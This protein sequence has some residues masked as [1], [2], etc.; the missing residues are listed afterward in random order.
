MFRNYALCYQNWDQKKNYLQY[1]MIILGRVTN[2]RHAKGIPLMT[3]H[4]RWT[5]NDFTFLTLEEKC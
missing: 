4:G 1:Y 3:K 5:Y 2:K